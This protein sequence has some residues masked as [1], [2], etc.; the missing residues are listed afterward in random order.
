MDEEA[1]REAVKKGLEA[2]KKASDAGV[3]VGKIEVVVETTAAGDD[4]AVK[5]GLEAVKKAALDAK[6]EVDKVELKVEVVAGDDDAQAEVD[7]AEPEGFGFA[8]G[9]LIG[10]CLFLLFLFA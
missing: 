8:F 6:V 4:E 7:K 3:E 1:V 9:C 2:V 10:I 5:K